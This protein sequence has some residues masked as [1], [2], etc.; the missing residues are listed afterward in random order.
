MRMGTAGILIDPELG[1][2]KHGKAAA[3]LMWQLRDNFGVTSRPIPRGLGIYIRAVDMKKIDLLV[4]K[5]KAAGIR[6]AAVATTWQERNSQRWINDP[7]RCHKIQE[8]LEQNEIEPHIWGYPWWNAVG[9]FVQELSKCV[10]PSTVL[11]RG[12]LNIGFTSYGSYV[13]D[14]PW[15]DFA[16]P[17][18]FNQTM[19]CDYGSPQLY[20]AT[21]EQIIRGM[22]KYDQLGFNFIIPSY[23]LYKTIIVDGKKTYRSKTPKELEE[24]FMAFVQSDIPITSMIGW[25][26]NFIKPNIIPILAKW[27][28]LIDRGITTL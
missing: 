1:L 5:L 7:T 24:H 26:D 27:S 6:W 22:D 9:S 15:N 8:I 3:N 23:G 16:K 14:F 21:P 4:N 11:R 10:Y 19:E 17:K 18:V 25:A 20:E 2:R 28:K 13:S 12:D